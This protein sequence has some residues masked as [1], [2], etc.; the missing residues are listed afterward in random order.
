VTFEDGINKKLVA[1]W[2]DEFTD[3]DDVLV[4]IFY[5][6]L[7]RNSMLFVGMNPSFNENRMRSLLMYANYPDLE[8][9]SYFKWRNRKEFDPKVS[10]KLS[11]VAQQEHPFF[12]RF[13]AISEYIGNDIKW[14]HVDLFHYR[15][16]K[17]SEFKKI[18]FSN[19]PQLKLNCFGRKQFEVFIEM[20]KAI[21][22]KVIIV[23]NALASRI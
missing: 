3:N 15:L 8:V 22:P 20:L 21:N 4:P 10:I 1:I 6:K 23:A 5:P 7:A 14:E 18:I 11:E 13:G 9:G 16:T 2:E 12:K 17:Q 19:E